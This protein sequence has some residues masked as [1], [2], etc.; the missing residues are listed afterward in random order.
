MIVFDAD[1]CAVHAAARPGEY[2]LL[3]VSDTGCGMDKETLDKIFEPFFTTKEVGHGTGLG[4]STVYGIIEQH[5]GFI[6]VRSEPGK[7]TTFTIYLPRYTGDVKDRRTATDGS[8]LGGNRE[9]VLVVED[10]EAILRLIHKMMKDLGYHV[11]TSPGPAKA[12]E[13]FNELSSGIDLLVSDVI[14]PEMSGRDLLEVLQAK[15]PNLKYL[16]MSG[17]TAKAMSNQGTFNEICFIQ[18][19]FSA[20]DLAVKIRDVLNS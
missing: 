2:V 7:G 3:E 11:I 16:F 5:N 6:D 9:T 19:P 13:I 12:I 10:D 4:L 15:Q 1:Y 17:Y 8:V 14:M 18:K 20:Q